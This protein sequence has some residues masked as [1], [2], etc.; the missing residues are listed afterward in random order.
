MFEK[1]ALEIS[2]GSGGMC[3]AKVSVSEKRLDD[4]ARV[5]PV[6][7]DPTVTVF[8]FAPPTRMSRKNTR[9]QTTTRAATKGT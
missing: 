6:V 3:T 8:G 5:C 2:G 1:V 7:I 9:K 4:R